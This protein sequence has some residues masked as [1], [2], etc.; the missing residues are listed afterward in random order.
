MHPFF[1]PDVA[2][3]F[4]SSVILAFHRS[5]TSYFN[6]NFIHRIHS[7]IQKPVSV[8]L[9]EYLSS[10]WIYLQ[11][12]LNRFL[13]STCMCLSREFILS[14][15]SAGH[16]L[17]VNSRQLIRLFGLFRH[18][19]RIWRQDHVNSA[20]GADR[21]RRGCRAGRRRRVQLRSCPAVT[22]I[23]TA[24]DTPGKIPTVATR[25]LPHEA[26]R[27]VLYHGK[28]DVRPSALHPV[29]RRLSS[30][31]KVGV[32]N[33]RSVASCDK[34]QC[35]STWISDQKF[36]AVGL[37]ETWHDGPDSPALLA[38]A[39]PG[40]V[41]TERSR[42]RTES[43]LCSTSTNHGGVC[44]LYRHSLHARVINTGQYQS[45]EHGAV[46]LHGSGLKALFVVVYR[47]GS[48]VHRRRS[49][50]TSSLICWMLLISIPILSSWATLTYI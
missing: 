43:Q 3:L 47:P 22:L 21:S 9:T 18:D 40:Y 39:P 11:L 31:V 13:V 26:P 46:F 44:L 24:S 16:R 19:C 36:T 7:G 35:I 29:S 12:N 38:C 30:P 37:V 10:F 25:R 4:C 32:L 41:F 50:W 27:S 42:P 6:L 20:A 17:N 5:F 14:R 49:S 45:F 8:G 28:R 48:I 23:E 34:S 1:A 15:R 2:A 33:S